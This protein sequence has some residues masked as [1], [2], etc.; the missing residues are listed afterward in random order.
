MR[1]CE[2]K[3]EKEGDSFIYT[4]SW[5]LHQIFKCEQYAKGFMVIFILED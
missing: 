5:L 2:I 4:I 1:L 3:R